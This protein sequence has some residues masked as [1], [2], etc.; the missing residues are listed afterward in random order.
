MPAMLSPHDFVKAVH[1]P[2]RFG[3]DDE[4]QFALVEDLEPV[5]PFDELIA[6]R[7]LGRSAWSVS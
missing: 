3:S 2:G 7:V 1:S 4:R 6:A 5:V